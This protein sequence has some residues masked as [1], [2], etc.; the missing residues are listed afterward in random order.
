M[1]L[2]LEHFGLQELPFRITPSVDFFYRGSL[3]GE[4]LDALKYAIENG[5][6]IL[7]VF[8][9]VGSGKSMLCR[10]LMIDIAD[11]TELVYVANPSLSDRE[12]LFHIAEELELDVSDDRHQIARRLQNHLLDLHSRGKRV[13][14]CID[15]AQAMPDESL[16]QIRLLSNL[17]TGK[18]KII[19]IIMFGQPELHTKLKQQHIRQ[20][21]ERI[22]SSFNLQSLK[23]N[24]VA[25][26][27]DSRLRS[28][29][30]QAEEHLF[31]NG[32]CST[33]AKVS[34]GISRRINIL[35]DKAMLAAFADDAKIISA[36]HATQA[37]RDARY[38][39]MLGIS[40]NE[41]KQTN[42][43]ISSGTYIAIATVILAL[44]TTAYQFWPD[45]PEPAITV[46]S[47][48]QPVSTE[49]QPITL[50]QS[51]VVEPTTVKPP[52]VEPVQAQQPAQ[53]TV[54]EPTPEPQ[55]KLVDNPRW[56]S[57]PSASYLRR[58]LNATETLLSLITE[59]NY[60]T[61]RILTVPRNR[62]I[63]IERYLRDLARFYSI[64]NILV[65]PSFS[66]G[67]ANFVITYGQYESEFQAELFIQ[68]LPSF[69][70]T[71]KPFVQALAVAQF[72]SAQHW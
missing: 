34:Q 51:V 64:R 55:I 16:E 7:A 23:L 26:Y 61:A 45:S 28:A 9:E 22:T 65:Y 2:Y 41:A 25:A 69:F 31:S 56:H 50:T 29:G 58:R 10:R 48:D 15:E 36:S 24:E 1:S 46:A 66:E 40:D 27:I 43:S 68:E 33:I 57:F 62:A 17:E 54:A 42:P 13:I 35:C 53:V 47:L 44:G 5:E 6:G 32:A 71:A 59:P 49:A 39:R 18:E 38:Q 12:I 21:R 52:A 63:D 30:Y 19:Q 4:V 20:L 3:R 14:V 70:R 60:Y 72:E 8:G 37:A 11:E 67:T